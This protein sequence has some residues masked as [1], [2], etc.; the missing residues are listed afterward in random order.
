[1]KRIE[2]MLGHAALTKA[3]E[4]WIWTEVA[5]TYVLNEDDKREDEEA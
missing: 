4:E 5:K 3:V 1:M 2:Y